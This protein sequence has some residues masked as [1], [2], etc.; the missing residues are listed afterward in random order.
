MPN[1]TD[2]IM[3]ALSECSKASILSIVIHPFRMIAPYKVMHEMV[4]KLAQDKYIPLIILPFPENLEVHGKTA[5]L[6]SF[7][8]NVEDNSPCTVGI[9]V[10]RNPP[11][12]SDST[13]WSFRVALFF[14]GGP[15]DREA[16]ALALRMSGNPGVS[17][18]LYRIL[19]K[20]DSEKDY[21]ENH[22]DEC[23]VNRFIAKNISNPGVVFKEFKA[24]KSLQVFD[25]V[26]SMENK[27]ELVLVGKRRG[28]HSNLEEE[29]NP[30]VEYKELGVIGD[31]LAS[32]DFGG[33]LM[34]ILV[35]QSTMVED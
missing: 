2:R 22:L 21:R 12:Y 28:S 1:S 26:R 14:L 13:K 3:R 7:I 32:S 10:D 15:D 16:L 19:L 25:T 20:E 11:R 30:W 17:I 35:M 24:N 31:M 29:M 27:Y 4:C 5:C 34:S 33:G 23:L 6:C 8:A 18:T 9:F